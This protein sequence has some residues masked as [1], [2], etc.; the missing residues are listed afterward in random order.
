MRKEGVRPQRRQRNDAQVRPVVRSIGQ[1][2]ESEVVTKFD[3]INS[4][5]P[6]CRGSMRSPTSQPSSREE[7]AVNELGTNA[8]SIDAGQRESVCV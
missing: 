1:C 8:V 3:S 7:E 2:A 4:S 5:A 6:H